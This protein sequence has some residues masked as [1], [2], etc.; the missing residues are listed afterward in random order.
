MI[1]D[2]SRV[3]IVHG[4]AQGSTEEVAEFMATRLRAWGAAVDVRAATEM[5]DVAD[6]DAV[7]VGSAVHDRALLPVVEDFV[8]RRLDLLDTMP[9]WLFSVGISPSLRGPIGGLLRD[10]VP[11]RIALLRDLIQPLDYHAFAGLVPRAGSP[12]LSRVLLRL[13]GGRYGDLRDWLEIEVW[14]MEIA[15]EMRAITRAA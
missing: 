14:T 5:P 12:M 2:G 15:H 8:L 4:S 3:L 9:V 13:C 7:V 10:A 6:H 1:V 11:P